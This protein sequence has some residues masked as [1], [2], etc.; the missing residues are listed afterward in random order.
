[1]KRLKNIISWILILTLCCGE[2]TPQYMVYAAGEEIDTQFDDETSGG[3]T[4]VSADTAVSE[5]EAAT[6]ED[7]VSEDETKEEAVSEDETKEDAVSE[8]AAEEAAAS[9]EEDENGI[10]QGEVY[11]D[12][13]I[14]DDVDAGE[15]E[16]VSADSYVTV[17]F[18]MNVDEKEARKVTASVNK[19][20]QDNKKNNLTYDYG[21]EEKAMRRAAEIA[22]YY[23]A[24]VR[25]D[26]LAS[27][28][29]LGE[30]VRNKARREMIIREG[31]DAAAA[32]A[33]FRGISANE[34]INSEYGYMAV[35][36]VKFQGKHYWVL[37]L[38]A[39]ATNLNETKEKVGDEVFRM[40]VLEKFISKAGVDP[41]LKED[42]KIK[43]DKD[44][45]KDLPTFSGYIV[46]KE[47]KPD[48]EQ[49]KVV[50]SAASWTINKDYGTIKNNKLTATA[51]EGTEFKISAK[52]DHAK[53]EYSFNYNVRVIVHV[54]DIK[55]HM[56]KDAVIS[57]N[58]VVIGLDR[59]VGATVEVLPAD[60][61]DKT[62]EFKSDNEKIVRVKKPAK[63]G[64]GAVYTLEGAGAGDTKVWA[65]P[66]DDYN[67]NVKAYQDVK[68]DGEDEM[69][70]VYATPGDCIIT[71]DTRVRLT[72]GTIGAE[73]YYLIY[74]YQV[75]RDKDG[76]ETWIYSAEDEK[77]RDAVYKPGEDWA[78]NKYF[79]KYTN[80]ITVPGNCF[81][82]TV[83][84]K[85]AFDK[86]GKAVY[87]VS[88]HL[89]WLYRLDKNDWGDVIVLDR[90]EYETPDD[91]PKGL[92]VAEAS[93]PELS[94]TGK[95]QKP[96]SF[97]VYYNK[98]RLYNKKDYTIKYS[99]NVNATTETSKAN[100]SFTFK[101]NIDAKLDK[102]F[103]I[104]RADIS[105][106]KLSKAGAVYT[107]S[108]VTVK[109]KVTMGGKTLKENVDYTIDTLGA[110]LKDI[111]EYT[112]NIC[113][114]GNYDG[115][116]SHKFKIAGNKKELP[117]AEKLINFKKD[118]TIRL[119]VTEYEYMPEGCYPTVS[120]NT[121]TG[122]VLS[123]GIDYIVTYKNAE[124]AGKAT[125]VVTGLESAGYKG[126]AS[127]KY[128][129]N[130]VDISRG[131]VIVSP[132]IMSV[133][134][135]GG[136]KM[137]MSVI[138]KLGKEENIELREGIDYTVKYK[139]NK[140]V[141]KENGKKG[142]Y[143]TVEGKGG[144]K[145]KLGPYYFNILPMTIGNLDGSAADVEYSSK[146]NS[147]KTKFEIYDHNG[148][149]LKAGTDYDKNDIAYRYDENC[150]VNV[151]GKS[152]TEFRMAGEPVG[153]KDI[154]PAGTLLQVRINGKGN[155][156]DYIRLRYR[157]VKSSISKA[158]AFISDQTY[159]G[160]EIILNKED[161]RFNNG[162]KPDDFEI[163]GYSNNIEAGTAKVIVRGVGN[164][165][166]SATFSFKIT[167]MRKDNWLANWRAAVSED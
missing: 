151:S 167:K 24:D 146:T 79:I 134:E 91:L 22:V 99:N 160:E 92:W 145:G 25:P 150:Y 93:M 101:G 102:Q 39:A 70:E 96:D 13:R 45:A 109:L 131:S 161:I 21:L 86:D 51:A 141:A 73:I 50:T 72:C 42:T 68:V 37:E 104:G 80:P 140:K 20:R 27:S 98:K 136:A 62:F 105:I 46:S 112:I 149:K 55:I 54:K 127:K 17:S 122:A 44:K 106:A 87:R 142:P 162:V 120:V 26:G 111:G 14:S 110:E 82:R 137:D 2:F 9:D 28:S 61:D 49:L 32:A 41:S 113:G 66:N 1:M 18:T 166:G 114:K 64:D 12:G 84:V 6:D 88:D 48:N 147:Y 7:A 153:D 144:Y 74:S 8:D 90:Q 40:D 16:I 35:G 57:G 56:D 116:L 159:T 11:D 60:A 65:I 77:K 126:S 47:H 129:I 119:D 76:Y 78:D 115:V 59:T 148:K 19:L 38:T 63:E 53:K 125:V 107:G 163:V 3:D 75:S 130:K 157:V 135:K 143:F 154:P 94:Y 103:S 69:C 33:L 89:D 30:N 100:A 128:T 133:Y 10:E 138:R 97:R 165:G 121:K 139:N 117:A 124:K 4:L 123:Q 118:V 85:Q 52:V 83:A 158:K 156:S 23:S 71:K 155:Y 29:I 95:A 31:N 58:A 164:Y 67:K 43:V 108:P 81:I 15:E 152:A 132:D 36:H 34:L 5:D